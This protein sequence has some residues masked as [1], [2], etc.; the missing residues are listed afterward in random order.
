MIAEMFD[1]T[2]QI[3]FITGSSR[4]IGLGIAEALAD[5]GAEVVL[6]SRNPDKLA[7]VQKDFLSKGYKAHVV[8]FDVTDGKAVAEGIAKIEKE[9]GPIDILINN[10]GI[11]RRAP[12]VD[13]PEEAWRAVM[14]TNLNA[15]FF[16]AQAVS[17]NMVKRQSGKIINICS[18]ASEVGR[19]TIVPYTT[20]KGAV[21]M[22]TKGMCCELAGHGIQ[23]NGIGPGYFKTELNTDLFDNKEFNDWVCSRTPAGRWGDMDELKGVAVF[24]ASQAASFI[25]GQILYVDGGLLS[26]M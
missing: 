18:L 6:N 21:R 26:G 7:E 2:G 19:P 17:R 23:V 25:N 15:V 3:A 14:E 1:L 10:A 22:L 5:A 11:Q 12:F 20:A 24:L 9:I 16:V 8:A 4:G 13:I